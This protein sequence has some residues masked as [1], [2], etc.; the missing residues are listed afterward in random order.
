MADGRTYSGPF[1][2]FGR[3]IPAVVACWPGEWAVVLCAGPEGTDSVRRVYGGVVIG[4]AQP[5]SLVVYPLAFL[6]LVVMREQAAPCPLLAQSGHRSLHR[7][8]PLL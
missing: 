7:T 8:C 2:F 5:L 1:C 6:V 4:P 3:C